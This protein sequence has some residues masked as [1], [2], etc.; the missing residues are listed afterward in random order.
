MSVYYVGFYSEGNNKDKALDLTSEKNIVEQHLQNKVDG[1]NFYTPD[2]IRKL[3]YSDHMIEFKNPGLVSHNKGM[4]MVGNCAWRPLILLLEMEKINDG[5]IIVYRDI[6]CIKYPTLK[7]FNNFKNKVKKIL[8][9]VDYDF[10][11][12]RH[13]TPITIIEH[14]KTN[15]IKEVAINEDF[16][17]NFPLLLSTYLIFKKT[18]I[19]IDFLKEWN[20]LCLIRK[21]IDGEP[22]GVLSKKFKWSTPEQSIMSVII[23]N[24]VYEGKNN[25]P[26]KYPNFMI[27]N[28]TRDFDNYLYPTDFSYLK[29][30][31]D[32]IEGFG[33]KKCDNISYIVL[34]VLL[35]IALIIK[36]NIYLALFIVLCI[37]YLFFD[38]KVEGFENKGLVVLY[39]ENCR[40]RR[41]DREDGIK[42]NDTEFAYSSQMEACDTHVK[43]IEYIKYKNNVDIDVSITTYNT[44][45]ENEIKSKYSNLINYSTEKQLIGMNNIFNKSVSDIKDKSQNYN[46]I[47]FI[48]IDL[49]LKDEFRNYI[50]LDGNKI[51]LCWQEWTSN[52]CFSNND[53]RV[54]PGIMYFPK[55]YFYI[56]HNGVGADHDIMGK[57]KREYGLKN[58]EFGFL[59]NTYHAS[60]PLDDWNPLYY[61]SGY[62]KDQQKKYDEWHD[63]DLKNDFNINN[64]IKCNF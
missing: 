50:K 25:I 24:W 15:I 22:Y 54:G 60:H 59:T 45:Y 51:L 34:I 49:I 11:I 36:F 29:L 46:F 41:T 33:N 53:P 14:C 48:R 32:I 18:Q 57:L 8:K 38:K 2:I 12:A 55:K 42:K 1:Y 28:K 7:N 20:D 37:F 35:L 9:D 3:G 64:T 58:E 31:H 19:S 63:K 16:T 61:Y 47:L 21:Y 6:N 10:A 27:N 39:G 5:D 62:N 30:N 43:L 44:K 26:K 17:S 13:D 40:D 52:T 23:S 4:N 56:L